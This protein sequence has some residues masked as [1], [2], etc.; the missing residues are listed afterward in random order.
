M[1]NSSGNN[2][3]GLSNSVINSHKMIRR[4]V[5]PN[6]SVTDADTI[7]K[8]KIGEGGAVVSSIEPTQVATPSPTQ[9]STPLEPVSS[10]APDSPVPQP[11]MSPIEPTNTRLKTREVTLP[12]PRKGKNVLGE[13]ARRFEIYLDGQDLKR[14]EDLVFTLSRM[15]PGDP[16]KKKRVK[17]NDII[18]WMIPTLE[19]IVKFVEREL[20]PD[21]P[22]YGTREYKEYH[23]NM[24]ELVWQA[25]L[26]ALVTDL[27]RQGIDLEEAED[28]YVGNG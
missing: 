20:I 21:R 8:Q 18:R 10:E 11:T 4:R 22:K 15:V 6:V 25:A 12:K 26:T 13:R 23:S 14:F 2:K 7:I 16:R 5:R 24:A 27:R 28:M 1:D 19:R 3:A 9:A 17:Y